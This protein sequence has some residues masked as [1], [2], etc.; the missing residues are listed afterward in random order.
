MLKHGEN[1]VDSLG[2]EVDR[3]EKS[4]K[5]KKSRIK[6][7]LLLIEYYFCRKNILKF[8]I[9][10]WKSCKTVTAQQHFRNLSKA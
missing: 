6:R 3:I 4:L 5:V 8:V 7:Y 9:A 1:I 10:I 2:A